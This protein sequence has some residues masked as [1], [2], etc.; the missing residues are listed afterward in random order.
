MGSI[1]S[2]S[3]V[4]RALEV[5]WGG[6]TSAGRE[7]MPVRRGGPVYARWR[8]GEG[9]CVRGPDPR[10]GSGSRRVPPAP[11][12]R[13]PSSPS[14]SGPDQRLPSRCSLCPQYIVALNAATHSLASLSSPLG[15]AAAIP[16][17]YI[18]LISSGSP[19]LI[20]TY[21]SRLN[22]PFPLYVDPK[23]RKLYKALGMTRKTLD[24]GSEEEKGSYITRGRVANVV[25]STVVSLCCL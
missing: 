24:G 2:R 9:D 4:R 18:L 17:L 13:P 19:S 5:R 7:L 16:P 6:L 3:L 14:R 1:G 12:V 25:V 23:G 21:R 15:S 8:V 22:C 11:L 10:A 20:S